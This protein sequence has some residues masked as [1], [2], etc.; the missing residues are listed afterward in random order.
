MQTEIRTNWTL[1]EVKSIY[2][3]PLLEL[4]FNAATLHRKYNDTAEVQVC[5]LLSIKTGGCSEDCAYCPQ[6]ARYNTGV[7]VQALMKKEE[8]LSYAQ[9]AKDAGSTRFCMGAAWREV[10]DNRDFD[11]VLEMVKDVNEMGMEVCC[12]LGMLTEEQAKKLADAGLYAYNHNLDTSKEHYGEIITTRTYEDRLETLDHVRKAGVTVCCGGI[13]GL[14]ETHEDRINM[15]HT[16]ATLPEHPESVPINALVPI[17]GTPLEHNHKVDVWD[18]VRMIATARV[19]MPATMV[20]LSAGRTDMS[21]AEQA[22]CFMAGANS[23][24]AGDKLLTTPN[25]SFEEDNAMFS[26]LGLKPRE[27]FKAEKQYLSEMV[28]G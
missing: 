27:A 10:R 8:V 24:F 16:L 12:T 13:I 3:T 20:R 1:E 6:A 2:D 15:L 9:K 11:R 14:G 4:V 22:L 18:M 17:A 19:L 5:T 25:P 21:T 23:I 7:N 28:N 26:L